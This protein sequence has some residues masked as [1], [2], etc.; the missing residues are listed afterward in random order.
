MSDPRQLYFSP[1]IGALGAREMIRVGSTATEDI[2]AAQT[3]LGVEADG[4][5]GPITDAAVRAFQASHGLVVDGIVGPKTWAAMGEIGKPSPSAAPASRGASPAAPS[6][7][8]IVPVDMIAR[9]VA[10]AK[11]H[12]IAA[13]A[14]G[15]AAAWFFF[16]RR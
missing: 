4:V 1:G 16:G 5:F 3:F 10:M 7:A 13:G 14:V 9:G 15:L 6:Q 12:P 11:A 2:K 8:S